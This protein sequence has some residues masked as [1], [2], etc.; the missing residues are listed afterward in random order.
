MVDYQKLVTDKLDQ[1]KANGSY[2]YFLQLHKSARHFPVFY[3]EKDGVTKRAVNY[4]S[5]DYLG[6]SVDEDVIGKLSFVLHHSGTGSGGTRNISGTTSQHKGLEQTIADWYTKEAALVFGSAYL[7]NL[8]ALQTLGRQ[9]PNAIFIS[10]EE[11]HASIIEGIKASGGQKRIFRHNDLI[12]LEEI[13]A[14]LPASQPKIIVFESVY[15]MTGTI[16]PIREIVALAKKYHA[17]T[18]A[19]EVHGVGLYGKTGSGVCE[20]EN[21]VADVDLI[22]GTLAK[23]I[24]V[25]GGYLT[26][27]AIFMDF[28]RSF[29]SGFIF[30]TSLPPALCAAAEKSIQLIQKDPSPRTLVAGSVSYLR[31]LLDEAGIAYL[32]N[33][34]HITRVMV[35]GAEKCKSL[36]DEL[37]FTHGIYLQPLNHP[38]VKVGEEGFRIIIT[39]KHTRQHVNE[40]VIGLKNILIEADSHYLQE[41]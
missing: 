29:G 31:R 33:D 41:Q 13:L 19:D 38:T 9:L 28:I 18:Y 5:N 1:L 16:A 17:L 8:T 36:A 37:L 39:A 3:F 27:T 40:L 20:Q 32:E 21:M 11:N 25:L 35:S 23:S 26:G 6:M 24:G 4:C 22:N 14:S 12:H 34:S 30:T 2:R 7:T 10:D 15:S